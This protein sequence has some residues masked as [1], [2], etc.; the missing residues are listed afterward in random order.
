MEEK[1]TSK[2]KLSTIYGII[3]LI[4]NYIIPC[5]VLLIQFKFFQKTSVALKFTAIGLVVAFILVFKFCRQINDWLK[6]IK[7]KNLLM[8]ISVVKTF[9]LGVVFTLLLHIMKEKIND[10]Q[11][12][13]IVFTISWC[14]GSIFHYLRLGEIDKQNKQEQD[15]NM[16]SIIREELERV[17]K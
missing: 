14:V 12:V 9:I 7:N 13:I 8:A 1:K 17:D 2:I 11:V 4:F 3:S 5:V 16:R 15:D 6:T 10:L